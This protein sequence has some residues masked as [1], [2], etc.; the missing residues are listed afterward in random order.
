MSHQR[1]AEAHMRQAKRLALAH[2]RDRRTAPEWMTEEQRHAW[3][4]V[5]NAVDEHRKSLALTALIGWGYSE[6]ERI[7]ATG[8]E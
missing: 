1:K 4:V 7:K 3:Y 2:V 8:V 5:Q 6:S